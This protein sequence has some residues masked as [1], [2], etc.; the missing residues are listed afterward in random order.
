MNQY[1]E[2]FF[3]QKFF[4]VNITFIQGGYRKRTADVT[5]TEKNWPGKPKTCQICFLS[6]QPLS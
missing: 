5:T 3:Q 4:V 6:G 1:R 2:I